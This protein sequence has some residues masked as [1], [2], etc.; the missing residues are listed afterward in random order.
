MKNYWF[1]LML[2]YL[3]FFKPRKPGTSRYGRTHDSLCFL[4]VTTL[5]FVR[6]GSQYCH[7]GCNLKTKQAIQCNISLVHSR[8]LNK[9]IFWYPYR[10]KTLWMD[11]LLWYS[12]RWRVRTIRIPEE[13]L[14]LIGCSCCS[15]VKFL[16]ASSIFQSKDFERDWADKATHGLNF[17][18]VIRNQSKCNS[19]YGW[20]EV[21][22]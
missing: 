17:V 21:E 1:T 20:L 2:D 5:V 15:A 4:H 6:T 14:L 3:S 11:L 12:D 16:L 7:I 18:W 13:W 22:L 8:G 9:N 10:C 19:V